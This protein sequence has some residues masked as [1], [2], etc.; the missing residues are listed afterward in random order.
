[1]ILDFLAKIL[2]P[3]TT[4]VDK[5]TT[6]DQERLELKNVLARIQGDVALKMAELGSEAL[7]ARAAIIKAE[8]QSTNVLTSSWRPIT[9]LVFTGL[10]VYSVIL[11]VSLP[12][13]L[14]DLMQISMG[15]YTASRGLEKFMPGVVE[16]MKK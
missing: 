5:V 13:Q 2:G 16:A 15:L 14:W 8:A 12:G 6:T 9:M 11:G 10:I 3:A 4:L 7:T 1:M